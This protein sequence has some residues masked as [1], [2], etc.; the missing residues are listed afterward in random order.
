MHS[1]AFD[2]IRLVAAQHKE[3]VP[4][5]AITCNEDAVTNRVRVS[6]YGEAFQ[7]NGKEPFKVDSF[8]SLRKTPAPQYI[9]RPPVLRVPPLLLVPI[10]TIAARIPELAQSFCCL[11]LS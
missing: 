6:I 4:M 9:V 11:K 5:L 8:V 3:V 10:L 7:G 1:S 2:T